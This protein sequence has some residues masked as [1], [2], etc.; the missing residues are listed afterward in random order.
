MTTLV[1][2]INSQIQETIYENPSK[3]A[4]FKLASQCD[5]LKKVAII[6]VIAAPIFAF[7]LPYVFGAVSCLMIGL[8]GYDVFNMVDN[9]GD[10]A[11]LSAEGGRQG[12]SRSNVEMLVESTILAKALYNSLHGERPEMD[13]LHPINGSPEDQ[14]LADE[15]E[16]VGERFNAR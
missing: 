16:M 8:V 10:A 3:E 11:K 12:D 7:F 6:A 5:S 1:N 4:K 14:S 15:A 13:R 9:L 2:A